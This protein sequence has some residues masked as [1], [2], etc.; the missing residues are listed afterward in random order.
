MVVDLLEDESKSCS[1]G[2]VV[3]VHT[4]ALDD[5]SGSRSLYSTASNKHCPAR[6]AAADAAPESINGDYT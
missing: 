6:R 4:I 2:V 3:G 5:S 1:A